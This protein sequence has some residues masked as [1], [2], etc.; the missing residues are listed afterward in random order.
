[1]LK[2]KLQKKLSGAASDIHLDVEMNIAQ[3]SLVALYGPSGSGK[4][5]IL[6]MLA[7]LFR[8]DSGAILCD[9]ESWFDSS[10]KRDIKT[11]QR[12]LA[13]VFQDYAL[14]PNLSVKENLLYACPKGSEAWVNELLDLIRLNELQDA[15]PMQLSGGQK[16]RLALAR[17]I[18]RR[19]KI[20]LLDEPLSALDKETRSVLQDE[21]LNVH[22]RFEMTTILVSHDLGEVFKL[23]DYVYQLDAGRI[24]NHGT[25]N[26]VF[27]QQGRS[28]NLN[29]QAQILE[30]RK[31]DILMV[32]TVLIGQDVVEMIV[33]HQEAAQMKI[34]EMINI[35]PKTFS[36][37]IA[38]IN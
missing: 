17:A 3:G 26:Q 22:R 7:G 19:P 6:R 34:G 8:P 38:R 29:L 11:Q 4:T 13:M 35:S 25:P 1:M 24:K 36:P 27:L 10:K 9:G 37:Q 14:F 21:I 28:A 33:D 15:S 20:L 5:S 12:S 18:A 23:S 32:L 30:I 31:E 16:Q 2:L